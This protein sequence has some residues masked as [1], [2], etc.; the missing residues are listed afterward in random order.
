METEWRRALSAARVERMIPAGTGRLRE[1]RGE[2]KHSWIRLGVVVGVLVVFVVGAST[3]ADQ[4]VSM[5]AIEP[6]GIVIV[7]KDTTRC[8]KLQDYC[9]RTCEESTYPGTGMCQEG[10]GYHGPTSA[11]S[12]E[13][14]CCTPGW[15]H[16]SYIGG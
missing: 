16:R 7:K 11:I 12:V 2:M 8:R 3:L 1:R 13:C 15:E 9:T 14:C 10:G 4:A 6:D 5:T